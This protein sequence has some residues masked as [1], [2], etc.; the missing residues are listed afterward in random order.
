MIISGSGQNPNLVFQPWVV[1]LTTE[2]ASETEE[3]LTQIVDEIGTAANLVS[4]IASASQEQAEGFEQ[5]NTG[6]M[7]DDQ[8]TQKNTA[9]AEGMA[10]AAATLSGQTGRVGERLSHFKTVDA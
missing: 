1:D 2:V 8:S 4:E 5:V 6:L 3:S 10:K 7:Q 9:T